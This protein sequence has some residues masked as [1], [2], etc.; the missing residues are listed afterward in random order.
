MISLK[1]VKSMVTRKIQL[2][3]TDA[4]TKLS[5]FLDT[6]EQEAPDAKGYLGTQV[7][8]ILRAWSG[9]VELYGERDV[10]TLA[11]RLAAG[12]P[13]KPPETEPPAVGERGDDQSEVGTSAPIKLKGASSFYRANK[14]ATP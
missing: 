11:L 13:P 10:L 14:K 12:N 7:K 4:D 6:I 3:V 9:L 5:Q 8:E 1:R 2:Y